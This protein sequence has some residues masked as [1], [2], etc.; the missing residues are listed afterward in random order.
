MYYRLKGF[1]FELSSTYTGERFITS[2]NEK[3]LPGFFLL[4]AFVSKQLELKEHHFSFFLNAFNLLQKSYQVIAWRPMPLLSF[5]TGISF[6]FQPN[7]TK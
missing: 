3:S 4:N 6:T 7:P 1:Q 2:D 5:Q